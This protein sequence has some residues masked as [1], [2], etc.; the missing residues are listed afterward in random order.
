[1]FSPLA[2]VVL[3]GGELEMALELANS[4]HQQ[5]VL[6]DQVFE[7]LVVSFQGLDLNVDWQVKS[8]NEIFV[9]AVL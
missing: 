8:L 1:M 3:C 7:K 5:V 9:S 6:V 4:R 2:I